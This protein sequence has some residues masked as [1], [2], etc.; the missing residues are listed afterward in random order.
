VGLHVRVPKVLFDKLIARRDALR[1]TNPMLN[2]SEAVRTL[3]EE[4]M[5]E[6]R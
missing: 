6:K 2:L 1:K 3:L 5:K 4:S